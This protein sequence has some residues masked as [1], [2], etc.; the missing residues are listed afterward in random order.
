ME[1]EYDKVYEKGDE[2]ILDKDYNNY[3]SYAFVGYLDKDGKLLDFH[4]VAVE[5]G[6]GLSLKS[7]F[8]GETCSETITIS[9][10]STSFPRGFFCDN[11]HFGYINHLVDEEKL[12]SVEHWKMVDN[13]YKDIRYYCSNYDIDLPL[14]DQVLSEY[15]SGRTMYSNYP[16]LIF[17]EY[18][19]PVI[20]MACNSDS[21][22][23]GDKGKCSVSIDTTDSFVEFK[24]SFDNNLFDISDIV[25][26][27]GWKYKIDDDGNYVF[28]N[29]NVVEG[30]VFD[31]AITPKKN[32]TTN[33][34][35]SIDKLS[36][37]T[38]SGYEEELK[39]SSDIKIIE[40]GENPNTRDFKI[41]LVI[42]LL[43]VASIVSI[44]SYKKKKFLD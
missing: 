7:F 41:I 11:S 15:E 40:V 24:T 44:H 2:I 21:I 23:Y 25:V 6:S 27:N 18:T 43:M 37:T 32:V 28:T 42:A 36:L 34:S 3:V 4:S 12:H 30:S 39:L 19:A 17:Q 22:K 8:I 26:Q 5:L 16:V 31:F 29:E 1:Y 13:S 33:A 10:D 20:E 38:K 9:Y 35:V 14:C